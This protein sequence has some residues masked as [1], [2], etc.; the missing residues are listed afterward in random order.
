MSEALDAARTPRGEEVETAAIELAQLLLSNWTWLYR[1]LD[2]AGQVDAK[3]ALQ[4]NPPSFAPEVTIGCTAYP[5][6]IEDCCAAR[7]HT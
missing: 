5:V 4:K 3:A 1:D 2:I 7:R 6:S